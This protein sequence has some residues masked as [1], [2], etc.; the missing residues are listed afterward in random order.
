MS[1]SLQSFLIQRRTD[2]PPAFQAISDDTG[3]TDLATLPSTARSYND[4]DPVP[5]SGFWYRN[6]E[7]TVNGVV[8]PLPVVSVG[9]STVTGQIQMQRQFGPTNTSGGFTFNRIATDNSGNVLVCGNL[10]GTVNFGNGITLS[11]YGDK[12]LA[13]VKYSAS[14]AVVWAR[15]YGSVGV[16]LSLDVAF[17]SSGQIYLFGTVSTGVVP[18]MIDFGTG[19][20][21]CYGNSDIILIKL[22]SDGNPLATKVAG[23]PGGDEG[24]S[25]FVDSSD[26][27]YISGSHSFFAATGLNLTQFGGPVLATHGQNKSLFVVKLNSSLVHQWSRNFGGVTSS[28]SDS[29]SLNVSGGKMLTVDSAGN[30]YFIASFVGNCD[31]GFGTVSAGSF[32]D[33][34]FVKLSGADGTNLS[35]HKQ[36]RQSGTSVCNYI[37]VVADSANNVLVSGTFSASTGIN[38]GGGAIDSNTD[39]GLGNGGAFLASYNAAGV[40]NWQWFVN[41]WNNGGLFHLAVDSQRRPVIA[42]FADGSADT[43]FGFVLAGGQDFIIQR[44]SPTGTVQFALRGQPF[45]DEV[46]SLAIGTSD[47]I[48][49]GGQCNNTSQLNASILQ[50]PAGTTVVNA[51]TIV[52]NPTGFNNQ[53]WISISP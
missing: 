46:H 42:L 44:F 10:Q 33:S 32:S 43:G 22:D 16:D 41:K 12:D 49:A 26:N 4:N 40:F 29:V 13:L 50:T 39:G 6:K 19:S 5:S 3:W 8:I 38:P 11:S 14:G 17:N 31:F 24:V 36:L 7:T 20:V 1:D 37:S 45:N 2:A 34:I 35:F 25:V 30:V 27:I 53:F 52:K 47:T 15:H 18:T 48:Y 21:Q 9:A 23:S 51:S 28:N